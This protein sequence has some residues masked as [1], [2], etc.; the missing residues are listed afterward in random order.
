MEWLTNNGEVYH[1]ACT[2][3]SASIDSGKCQ[4]CASAIPDAILRLAR[5]QATERDHAGRNREL[6]RKTKA[7]KQRFAEM[8]AKA[9]A[10]LQ[11]SSSQREPGKED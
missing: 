7:I 10:T 6:Q 1:R 2:G 4:H 9:D 8:Q 5:N 11:R 3:W